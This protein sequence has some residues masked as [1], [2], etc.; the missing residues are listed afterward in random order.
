MPRFLLEIDLSA[1]DLLR[2]LWVLELLQLR[3]TPGDRPT[4]AT[5]D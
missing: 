2:A 1:A 5:P 3:L 4:P